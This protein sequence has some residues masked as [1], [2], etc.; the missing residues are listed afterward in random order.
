MVWDFGDGFTLENQNYPSHIYTNPGKYIVTLYVYGYN[1]LTG[2]YK[3]SLV[4]TRPQASIQANDLDGCIGQSFTLNAPTHANAISYLWDFG[5]GQT[6]N[7]T[8]S[9]ATHVFAAAGSYIPSVLVKDNN[10]CQAAITSPDKIIINPAPTIA[11]TPVAPVVCKTAAVQLNAT[12]AATYEWWPATGLSAINIQN[13]VA[14]PATNTLYTVKGKDAIGCV[15][16]SAVTVTVATPFEMTAVTAANLCKGSAAQL[17]ANGADSYLWINNTAGLSALQIPNPVAKPDASTTYTLVG[18]D[19]YKCYSDTATVTVTVRPNPSVNAGPDRE[20]TFGAENALSITNSPDVVRWN[21]TPAEFLSCTSCAAPVS[22]P[23]K[24]MDYIV[25]VYNEYN[26]SAKDT[27]HINAICTGVN[28]F[29]PNTFSPNN[30]GKN[31]V[32]GIGGSGVRIIRSFRVYNRWGEII[33]ERKNFYP[34]DI[35]GTWN[36][37]NKGID[38]DTG[39]YVYF[40]ELECEAN[41]IFERKGT[42]LLVR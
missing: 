9:F 5:N 21:W 42:V 29:I 31:E 8:D 13:P 25:S 19:Q 41:Q 2:T 16:E 18:Y 22:R 11:L 14:F 36:G 20:T 39:V 32:F 38:V 27:V 24:S 17:K 10:G 6:I 34:N 1:G 33:F 15:G 3:D 35:S 26:C 23:Y 40:A 12:G 37:K 7:A 28:I 30:D 4:I